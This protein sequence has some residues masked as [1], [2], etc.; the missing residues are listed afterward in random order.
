VTEDQEL[1][2]QVAVEGLEEVIL[3]W[4]G[5]PALDVNRW[6]ETSEEMQGEGYHWGRSELV[7][8]VQLQKVNVC[9]PDVGRREEKEVSDDAHHFVMRRGQGG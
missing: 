5:E 9:V 1:V 3:I 2:R 6:M 4:E 8:G 7:V